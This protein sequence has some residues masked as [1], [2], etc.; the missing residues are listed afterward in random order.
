[1]SD[2]RLCGLPTPT[3]P[4]TGEGTPGAFCCRGCLE[5]A[6]ALDD[7]D[8]DIDADAVRARAGADAAG[9]SDGGGDGDGD[10]HADGDGDADGPASDARD[11]PADAAETFLAVDGMRCATCEAF[12]ELRGR[13]CSGVRAVDANYA[14]GVARVWHDPDVA[15]DDLADRLS[16]YG[17]RLRSPD[18]AGGGR[19]DAAARRLLAGGA[20]ALLVMPWY[21]F[22]L[23][24]SYLGIGTPVLTV[25]ATSPVGRYLPLAIL[26]LLS[27]VVVF[28]TGYPVLRGAY[29][30]VRT[31]RPNTDLLIA[32]AAL[33][34]YAYSTV[35]LAAGHSH[36]YYDVSIAVILAVTVGGRYESRVRDRATGLLSELTA[37]R[38]R[39]ATRLTD[40][41]GTETVAVDAL[42]GGDRVLVRPGERVPVDGVVRE[43][44]AAVDESV[45][46]GESLPATKRPGDRVIAGGVATD[47]ALV[48]EADGGGEHT[49]DRIAGLVWAVQSE[50]RG[51]QRFADR[52]ATVFVPGVLLLGAAVAAWRLATG[53]G[54]GAALLAGLTV[55]VV[56][57]PCALGLATPLAAAAG[58][59]DGLERG[60]VATTGA[61]F[62]RAPDADA[63]VFDKTGTLTDGEARVR[64]VHG[65][66]ETLARAAAVERYSSHPVAEAIASA[67]AGSGG[68]DREDPAAPP[69][70]ATAADGGPGSNA[71]AGADGDGD[72]NGNGNED[73]GGIP[74][75]D[76]FQRHPGAGVSGRVDGERV[77]VGTPA[78][79]ERE[80][81]PVDERVGERVRA[82]REAGAVPA[83]VGWD[84]RARGVVTVG[85]R[86]RPDWEAAVE[87]AGDGRAV[88]VLTGDDPAAAA[89]FRD[90]PAVDRTIA[91]VPP[92]GKA[93]TVRRLSA[94]GT[95]AMAGDGTN[96]APALAAADVGIAVGDA[97]ARAAE[98]ADAVV[99]DGGPAAVGTVL[100][101]AAGTRRRIRGNV[102]WAL[103][104]N[105][106]AIP[107]AVAGLLNPLL[108]AVAMATSSLLVA[109]NSA[110]PIL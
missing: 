43:G 66:P 41:G 38:V 24:P 79:I 3:P 109:A 74:E 96:D 12:V 77:V 59:R 106:V 61:L 104:Y 50:G 76:G 45:L 27:G 32:V 75:A 8:L 95:V 82:A 10:G 4:V 65:H 68:T 13:E 62:E 55:L 33:S 49:L 86:A 7:G 2:C 72:G 85:D 100:D 19:D 30:A 78:L 51:V 44:T 89:R 103:V 15:A 105:A 11:V 94:R 36:L 29:V 9:A 22:Y 16:G 90:H 80:V 88:I 63:V 34:A 25:D 35:A 87:A 84:G 108:A 46:T 107:L 64:A 97:T 14:A 102:G 69:D 23:Y 81:G 1:M 99:V 40:D 47:D 98:A 39:E 20:A 31:R 48:V 26:G 70:R 67:A 101:L 37:A 56:S 21:L 83:V 93:E 58:L 53:A 17:Y 60:I 6:R 54:V 18:A 110:R 71:A 5:V 42:S 52:L 57:C 28:Y 92:D 73:A 91:G